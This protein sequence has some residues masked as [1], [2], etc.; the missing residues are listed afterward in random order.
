M[1]AL[2]AALAPLCDDFT[3][4]KGVNCVKNKD[5]KLEDSS[6]Q[7]VTSLTLGLYC[8]FLQYSPFLLPSGKGVSPMF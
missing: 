7:E 8:A 5:C 3:T 6:R 4:T 1:I 2:G